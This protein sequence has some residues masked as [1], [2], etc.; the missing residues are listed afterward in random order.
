MENPRRSN[1]GRPRKACGICKAQK[2]RCTEE[3]PSCKRCSRLGHKCIYSDDP[4]VP[5]Q[6]TQGSRQ[7][8]A[9]VRLTSRE[10]R[11][12]ERQRKFGR[13]SQDVTLHL[14]TKGGNSR[15]ASGL[16]GYGVP[17]EL[18][19]E[20]VEIYF[21]N[22]YNA[23]LLLH[24]K[25]FLEEIIEG[26]ACQHILL[27]VCA[28]AAKFYRDENDK[29]VLK[30]NGSMEQWAK[31]A[32]KLVFEN[33]EELAQENI[34][35]FLNLALF[36]HS[37][38]AW[39]RAYLHKGNAFQLQD[40]V[41]L[42]PRSLQTE[43]TLESEIRRRRFWACY[44][45][46][47]H[48]SERGNQFQ[49]KG[50][51]MKL[52]FPWREEDFED[53]VGRHGQVCIEDDRSDGAL[54]SELIRIMTIWSSVVSLLKSPDDTSPHLRIP[55]IMA[56]DERL[57]KWWRA[58]PATLKLTPATIQIM[59][60]EIIPRI[61]HINML[62]HQSICALHASLVPLFCGS[63]GEEGWYT[64]RQLSAQ[65]AF[66]HAC[67]VSAHVIATLE[68]FPRTSALPMFMGYAAYCGCVIQMAF[69]SCSNQDI[70]E[71]VQRNVRANSRLL[72]LMSEDWKFASL[73]LSYIHY[74]HTLHSKNG[75]VL[76]DEPKHIARE[77][78]GVFNGD[79]FSAKTS[80]Y[81]YIE[82]LR[83]EGGGYGSADEGE[84]L[85]NQAVVAPETVV[86]TTVGSHDAQG[87]SLEP[88]VPSRVQDFSVANG[89]GMLDLLYPFNTED[90]SFAMDDDTLDFSQLEVD[91]LGLGYLDTA[92]WSRHY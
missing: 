22:V 51:I 59:P 54:F 52:P 81:E 43:N 91:Q 12:D 75:I 8:T 39:R 10:K 67:E 31:K 69:M 55:A 64:I 13:R 84:D 77:K 42:G 16:Q 25:T 2:I 62:Y 66:E 28:W 45:M 38:G 33:A 29:T 85:E 34:V 82:L 18:V 32:G 71:R 4:A 72:Q 90:F 87:A 15:G 53:G 70:K 23:P 36:W 11:R 56:L 65:V 61:L 48:T 6:T 58:L 3:R 76:E 79:L 14:Q 35:T 63:Q 24:K 89:D 83:T 49:L 88:T 26:R 60:R 37:M 68:I 80:I 19:E 7:E 92:P 1:A 47:C 74:L 41:G 20:L 9:P 78:L 46:H 27:G 86:S 17:E 30:D 57:A 21:R 40:I 73:L 5:T 50:P 44:A